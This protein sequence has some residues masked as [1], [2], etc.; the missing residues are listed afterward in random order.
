LQNHQTSN[1]TAGFQLLASK[2][3]CKPAHTSGPTSDDFLSLQWLCISTRA[4]KQ[5]I[6]DYR[7]IKI[8]S[9]IHKFDMQPTSS[10]R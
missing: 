7:V 5:G 4:P 2:A 3:L 8:K 6:N 10:I 1:T 9:F